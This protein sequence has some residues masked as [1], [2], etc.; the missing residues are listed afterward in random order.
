LISCTDSRKKV[1]CSGEWALAHKG[2]EDARFMFLKSGEGKYF[3]I[4]KQAIYNYRLNKEKYVK[5]PCRLQK[6]RFSF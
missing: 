6:S 2:E 4:A 3:A 5:L 1:K